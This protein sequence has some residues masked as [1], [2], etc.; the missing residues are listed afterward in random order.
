MK[1]LKFTILAIALFVGGSALAQNASDLRI[2]EVMVTNDSSIVDDYGNHVGWIELFNTS[3]NTVNLAG[4]FVTDDLSNPT[5]SMIA[6][7]TAASIP[8]RSHF[9]LYATGDK[10]VGVHHLTFNLKNSTMIAL[11]DANGRTL[12]DSVSIPKMEANVSY[13]RKTDGGEKWTT[14][15][16]PTPSSSNWFEPFIGEVDQFKALDPFGIGMTVI[17]MTIVLGAL[18]ILFICF[19][20]VGKIA[21]RKKKDKPFIAKNAQTGEEASNEVNAA[22]ALALFLLSKQEHDEEYTV[23]TMHKVSRNYSPWNSKIYG[24][25]KRP[26]GFTS[27]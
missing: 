2:N 15:N 3:Y 4:L 9:I 6:K 12:I 22:I 26:G 27:F 14:Q 24:L 10:S 1:K 18:A 11:F 5:K 7:S 21:T 25:R 20:L 23:L 13:S 17:A 8:P 16:L 19:K